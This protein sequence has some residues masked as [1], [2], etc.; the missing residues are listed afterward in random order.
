MGR[1]IDQLGPNNNTP[2]FWEQ[3]LREFET[4]FQDSFREDRTRTEIMKLRMNNGKIDTYIAKFE[5]LARKAGYTA[6]NPETLWQFHMGLLQ[7]VLKDVMCSPPVIGYEAHKQRVIESVLANR[8]IWDI[9]NS[10]G[11][12]GR[13]NR[14][15]NPFQG[16]QYCN[17]LLG[18][19]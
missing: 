19:G 13:Q 4:Q 11:N 5:E 3:F 9:Q 2:I 8:V 1:V 12:F 15:N 17:R 14:G 18:Q 16:V 6:G 7:C 10:K